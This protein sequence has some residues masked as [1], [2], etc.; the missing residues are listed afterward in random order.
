MEKKWR[1]RLCALLKSAKVLVNSWISELPFLFNFGLK[2]FFRDAMMNGAGWKLVYKGMG[3]IG[4]DET[5]VEFLELTK[6]RLIVILNPVMVL[7]LVLVNLLTTLK[8]ME[9]S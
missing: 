6:D 7:V 1:W 5:C 9:L 4:K 2:R 3:M 8:L